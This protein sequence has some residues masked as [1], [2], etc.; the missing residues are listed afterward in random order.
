MLN[1]TVNDPNVDFDFDGVDDYTNGVTQ[2]K[3]NHLTIN[4]TTP[5]HLNVK[6]SGD[7]TNDAD[8]KTLPI[9]DI[10]L[11]AV[12]GTTGAM[13]GLDDLADNLA[14]TNADQLILTSDKAT[15]NG[16]VKITYKAILE[17]SDF[18]LLDY[19]TADG[20]QTFS[21]TLTYTIVGD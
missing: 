21:A 8:S 5:F 16:T 1:I 4:S 6:S 13:T 20:V 11:S 14:L 10:K 12:S 19:S 9:S 18:A 15:P 2:E 3:D 17:S 7:L